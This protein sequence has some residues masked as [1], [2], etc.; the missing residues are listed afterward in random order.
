MAL[1]EP[2]TKAID[3]YN[4]WSEEQLLAQQTATAVDTT[5]YHYTNAVG[6]KGI[7]ESQTIWFTDYRDLNDPSE[8][9]HGIEMCGEVIRGLSSGSDQRVVEFLD[10]VKRLMSQKNFAGRLDFFIASFSRARDDLGQWRAYAD[11]G[12]GFALGL[13]PDLFAVQEKRGKQP[14]DNLFV[15][16]VVYHPG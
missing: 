9:V 14:D 15:G 16:P 11:D 8:L 6:L 5:L 4:T 2:L 3:S 7:L 10:I 1:P 12:R 13:S